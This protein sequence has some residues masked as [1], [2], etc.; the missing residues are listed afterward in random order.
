MHQINNRI[1][2]RHNESGL[3]SIITVSIVVIIL[4]LM[5]TGFAKVMDRELRQS[6]DRELAVQANYA[7]ESG[8]ND[9]R[10]YISKE[11]SSDTAG[12]CLKTNALNGTQT[13]YF[14]DNGNV[15]TDAGSLVKYTCVNID[16]NPKELVYDIAAGQS[17]I[18]RV[19]TSDVLDKLYFSWNNKQASATSNATALPGTGSYP[20]ESYWS[21]AGHEEA[22]GVLRTTIYPVSGTA[23]LPV[24]G[25]QNATLETLASNYFMYPNGNGAGLV[26]STSIAKNGISVPGDCNVGNFTF[27]PLSI[28]YKT[29][30]FCNSVLTD[31]A[32]TIVPNPNAITVSLTATPPSVTVLSG[33]TQLSW[34]S[35]GATSCLGVSFRI[36]IAAAGSWGSQPK[37]LNGIES[38]SPGES[39]EY[40]LRC[41]NAAG[42]TAEASV[43]VKRFDGYP[44]QA[45]ANVIASATSVTAG[46]PVTITYNSSSANVCRL[47]NS[48]NYSNF[49]GTTGLT[50]N[51][52]TIPSVGASTTFAVICSPDPTDPVRGSAAAGV[53]VNVI[54]PLV[55]SSPPS[56][57]FY[58]R[59]TALYRDLTVSVQGANSAGNSVNFKKAQAVVDVTAK[60][61]DVLKRLQSRVSLDPDFNYPQFA[62]DSMDTLCKKL[63]LPVGPVGPSDYQSAIIDDANADSACKP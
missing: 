6:L 29:K 23:A 22:T 57:F 37:P 25:D 28:P 52:I 15:S 49:R 3:V 34:T 43:A 31:L 56:A 41:S 58:V 16:T 35:T 54:P 24:D 44:I 55:P 53:S 32:P 8:M 9:A 18:I 7:A 36:N 27:T 61:N 26:G 33:S 60:G 59:L 38:V 5:T 17:K 62:L 48:S 46:S 2:N 19:A 50:S 20:P 40:I 11:A 14:V 10:N 47:A 4:A 21:T 63:R 51:A 13:P 45:T 30:H 42:V 39:T 1:Q 12:D